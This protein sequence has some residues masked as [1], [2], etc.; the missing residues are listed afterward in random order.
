MGHTQERAFELGG[1]PDVSSI[2]V[3]IPSR[4]CRTGCPPGQSDVRR[5]ESR[6]GD[7]LTRRCSV[8]AEE[9]LH[10]RVVPLTGWRRGIKIQGGVRLR[11]A[12]EEDA[13]R[14]ERG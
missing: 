1:G 11:A 4:S 5:A 3:V 10:P 2:V 14:D 9:L 8:V 12:A 6:H 7:T 13:D